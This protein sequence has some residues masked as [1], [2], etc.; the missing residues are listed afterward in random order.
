MIRIIKS[1][2]VWLVTHAAHTRRRIL[3]TTFEK[4]DLKSRDHSGDVGVAGRIILK[5]I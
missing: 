5:F 3:H 4:G 1:K 2:N